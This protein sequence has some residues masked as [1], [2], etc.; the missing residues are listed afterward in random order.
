MGCLSRVIYV[1][2]QRNVGSSKGR[3]PYG[4][5]VFIVVRGEENSLHGEGR[6]VIWQP[7]SEV[8]EMRNVETVLG[9]IR[10]RNLG[11]DNWKAA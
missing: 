1:Q 7:K 11:I 3:E 10:E 6:Q 2:H 5:G 4:D 9:V 8:R